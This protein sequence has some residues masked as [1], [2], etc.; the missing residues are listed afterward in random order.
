LFVKFAY[1][2]PFIIFCI[3]KILPV[4]LFHWYSL[5][6]SKIAFGILN[7]DDIFSALGT[8]YNFFKKTNL[9]GK[10][11]SKKQIKKPA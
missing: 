8:S 1:V 10:G 6:I 3:I 7:P 9:I 2:S 5:A 11:N 4:L